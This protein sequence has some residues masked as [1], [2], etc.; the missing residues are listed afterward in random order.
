MARPA[1]ATATV[2][3]P[4]RDRMLATTG[5][6]TWALSFTPTLS[7]SLVVA[8]GAPG[9]RDAPSAIYD[10]VRDRLVLFGG[11]TAVSD[12]WALS[13][14]GTPQWTKLNPT[15]SRPTL[16]MSQSAVYDSKRDEMVVFGGFTWGQGFF[17]KDYNDTWSLKWGDLTTA[18]APALETIDAH[19]GG[20]RVTWS[21]ESTPGTPATV[22]RSESAGPWQDVASITADGEGRFVFADRLAQPGH[23]YGYRIGI[24][25]GTIERYFGEVWVN[26]PRSPGL[27][28]AGLKPNP[29][30]G[31][32]IVSFSLSDASPATVAVFD[33]AG[34][35]VIDD[36]LGALGPG[37]HEIRLEHGGILPAGVYLIRLTQGHSTVM[38]RGAVVR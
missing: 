28:L 25:N 7:W 12:A 30:R 1:V 19:A 3:D 9:D 13:L 4:G 27:A 38:V 5:G 2:Y 10:S 21:S 6:S 36:R 29:A 8:N 24:L 23:R 18:I 17:T 26:V 34:R 15:G 22:Y 14:S 37:E 11:A 31:G 32:M 20:V 16:R 33:L 35:K